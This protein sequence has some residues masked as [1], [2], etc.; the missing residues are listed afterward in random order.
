MWIW[1]LGILPCVKTTSLRPDANVEEHVSSDML[2]EGEEKAHQEVKEE[3]VRKNQ[4]VTLLKESTQLGCIS[5][6]LSEK[7]YS[8]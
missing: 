2:S 6:F 5:R 3:V 7:V 8:T 1:A 4:L